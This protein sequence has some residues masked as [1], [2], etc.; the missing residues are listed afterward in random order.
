MP[1]TASQASGVV[2]SHS[3]PQ[4]VSTSQS[5]FGSFVHVPSSAQ[6]LVGMVV[7]GSDVEPASALLGQARAHTVD[8][9]RDAGADLVLEDLSDLEKVLAAV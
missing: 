5:V 8:D 7:E 6:V 9:L 4:S 1:F 3:V 2:A